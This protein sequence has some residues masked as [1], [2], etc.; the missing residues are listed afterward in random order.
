MSRRRMIS[1]ALLVAVAGAV[2]V[3]VATYGI[4]PGPRGIGER[5]GSQA[6]PEVILRDVVMREI[7]KEGAQYRL[8]SDQAAYL[9]QTGRVAASGVTLE[10]SGAAGNPVVRAP[11]ASWDMQTGQIILPE[12]GSAR[13]GE[14]WSAS[15]PAAILSLPEQTM[16]ARGKAV[17]SGPDLSIAGDNLVWRWRDGKIALEAPKTRLVPNRTFRRGG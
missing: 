1:F 15:V 11:K 2:G 13:T 9:L 16:T 12:G 4:S 8:V 17:L 7:R 14:G 6:E 3:L 10:M 5:P